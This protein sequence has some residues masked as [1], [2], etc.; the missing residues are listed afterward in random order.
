MDI[1]SLNNLI[2][3]DDGLYDLTG[4]TFYYNKDVI[5]RNSKRY[6][7][8]EYQE[9][10]MDIISNDI[11]NKTDHLDV[12]CDINNIINPLSVKEGDNIIY[13][14]ESVIPQLS[15][16]K[17]RNDVTRREISNSRKAASIDPQRTKYINN[18]TES[19]PPTLTNKNSS[20]VKYKN[21]RISIGG[22][23]FDS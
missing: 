23:I 20:T 18:K 17:D 2:K 4:S 14:D 16:K 15:N 19:L 13:V 21:G 11:Y 12:L 9:M 8:S 22:D 3:D 10:R 6:I 7:V 5:L 1:N